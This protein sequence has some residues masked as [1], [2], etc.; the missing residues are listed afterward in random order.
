M[1][2]PF[3]GDLTQLRDNEVEEKLLELNKKYYQ[4]YRLG[5]Q[6]L[7]TQVATFVNIYKEELNRRNQLKLK[8]QLDGDMGQ[9]I[10]V[11]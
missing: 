9:L 2:H 10:N 6:D 8:Q 3:E 7:L 5:N 11:D 1:I 4:A